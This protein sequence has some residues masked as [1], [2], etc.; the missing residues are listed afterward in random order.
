[1]ARIKGSAKTGGRKKGTRNKAKHVLETWLDDD[2]QKI[3]D[4]KMIHPLTYLLQ[5]VGDTRVPTRTRIECAKIVMPYLVKKMPTALQ[6]GGEIGQNVNL[7]A[8]V[9]FVAPKV[10]KAVPAEIK[11]ISQEDNDNLLTSLTPVGERATVGTIV[12][13]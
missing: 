10:E 11:T 4:N 1:M 6:V 9:E 5:K 7:I 3:K 8:S 13:D 12:D 2:I